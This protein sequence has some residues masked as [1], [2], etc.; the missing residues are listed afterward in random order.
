MPRI[1]L[2]NRIGSEVHD[3]SVKV[4]F[5]RAGVLLFGAYAVTVVVG[6]TVGAP[7]MTLINER[8]FAGVIAAD[9]S[10]APAGFIEF[11]ALGQ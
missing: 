2:A 1:E 6:T 3:L 4:Y 8:N 5:L 7:T 10:F 9:S 11:C